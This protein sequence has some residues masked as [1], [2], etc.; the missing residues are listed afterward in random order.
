MPT[1]ENREFFWLDL[2]KKYDDFH[3]KP[4]IRQIKLKQYANFGYELGKLVVQLENEYY[5]NRKNAKN[6]P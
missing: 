1:A 5:K 6:L 3:C 2:S 4:K